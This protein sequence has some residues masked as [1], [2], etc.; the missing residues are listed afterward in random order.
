MM[1]AVAVVVVFSLAVGGK[2][3][4]II[5][6]A[7]DVDAGSEVVYLC[8]LM[9]LVFEGGGIIDRIDPGIVQWFPS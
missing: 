4:F 5:G 7:L 9:Y 2:A 8:F 3:Q 1:F 6:V